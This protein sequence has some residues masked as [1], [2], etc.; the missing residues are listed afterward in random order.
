MPK[1]GSYILSDYPP[2]A[3]VR[4]ACRR[5]P[6]QGQYRIA[7]LIDRFGPD[8]QMP[9]LLTAIPADCPKIKGGTYEDRC[10]IYFAETPARKSGT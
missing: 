1:G 8:F 3:V 5:C 6:R 4:F 10:G 9:G 2:D 7:T